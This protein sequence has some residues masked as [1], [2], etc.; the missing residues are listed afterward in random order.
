MAKKND[1]IKLKEVQIKGKRIPKSNP[2]SVTRSGQVA[3]SK[4]DSIKKANPAAGRLI[5]KGYK[6]SGGMTTYG[7]D[8]SDVIKN[9]LKPVAKGKK[10]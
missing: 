6:G 5:G 9:A 3:T 1:S 2:Q 10:K 7:D 8:S 4:I